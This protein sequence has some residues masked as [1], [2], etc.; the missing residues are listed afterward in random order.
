MC[1]RASVLKQ[2]LG[3]KSLF[4]LQSW[5]FSFGVLLLPANLEE[6]LAAETQRPAVVL[7]LGTS[8]LGF[9]DTPV[10]LV[11]PVLPVWDS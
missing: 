5:L 2:T 4:N 7:R 1:C 3:R 10:T 9:P 8:L 11:L 6:R